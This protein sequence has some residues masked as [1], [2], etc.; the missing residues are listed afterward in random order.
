MN[1]TDN[2]PRPDWAA[3]GWITD[4]LPTRKD[5]DGDG[6]VRLP[7]RPGICD[8]RKDFFFANYRTVVAVGQPWYSRYPRIGQPAPVSSK[9]MQSCGFSQANPTEPAPIAARQAVQ[10]AFAAVD[11][12]TTCLVA[13]CND[14]S[15]WGLQACSPEW[16]EL[17][18]IP[19]P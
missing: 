5:A 3:M 15:L 4:R 11:A 6:D 10:I 18:A 17:P 13:L 2:A 19:Q 8:P 16:T 12:K 9:V 7:I 1:E 14:G